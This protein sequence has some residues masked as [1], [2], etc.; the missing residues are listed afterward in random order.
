MAR[1]DV[2]GGDD[3]REPAL[4]VEDDDL[5]RPA[6]GEVGDRL[7]RSRRRAASSSRRRTRRRTRGRPASRGQRRRVASA[8]SAA[9]SR[10][11][12]RSAT[13]CPPSIVAREAVVSP[14]SSSL[15][16]VDQRPARAP[17]RRPAPRPTIWREDRV[18]ALAHLRPGVEQGERPVGL[19]PQDRPA[20]L[21][22]PV[23]DAR[24]LRAAGDPGVAGGA[25]GVARRR[26]ASSRGRRPG[27]AAGRSRTGR[28]SR[29]RCASGSPSRRCRPAR[30]AGRGARR[31]ANVDLGGAEAAHGA[32][33]R[34]V[35]VDGARLDVDVRDAVGA[36]GVARPRARGPC[37]RRWRRRR[38]R[39][40]S[41]PGRRRGGPPRR[42]PTV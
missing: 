17:G 12:P 28:R 10:R 40:R 42:S 9:R 27:P 3:P 37:P 38:C 36:A 26:A 24:V 20:A 39:R 14:V 34:V 8:S 41:G 6:V 21:A 11:A 25:V 18:D 15:L 29:A 13:A 30:R 19:G 5:G 16:R 23:A 1:P 35:R 2:V 4:V 22:H 7:R 32:G 33:R 31:C